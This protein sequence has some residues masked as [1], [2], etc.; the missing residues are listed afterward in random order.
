MKKFI[1]LIF[2]LFA[3]TLF[4]DVVSNRYDDSM[5]HFG[6]PGWVS[7]LPSDNNVLHREVVPFDNPEYGIDPRATIHFPEAFSFEYAGTKYSS[8]TVYRTGV[9]EFGPGSNTSIVQPGYTSLVPAIVMSVYFPG[10]HYSVGTTFEWGVYSQK[11]DDATDD[12]A[13]INFGPF[14]YE[15]NRY[16]AQIL[17]YRDGEVQVQFWK[18]DNPSS[19]YEDWM[20]PDFYDGITHRKQNYAYAEG[21]VYIYGSEGLRPGWIAKSLDVI[22]DVDITEPQ[23]GAGLLVQ[24]KSSDINLGGIIAYD[25][26]REHPVVGSIS[27]IDVVTSGYY[28]AENI[29][30]LY[31]WYFDEYYY[32]HTNQAGYPYFS[33]ETPS[34][35]LS[36]QNYNYTWNA[37]K[38]NPS[39]K[40]DFITRTDEEI[41]FIGAPAFKF[42]RTTVSH[43]GIHDFYINS[44]KYN[45]RQ[46]QSI[47][48]LPPRTKERIIIENAMGGLVELK[49]LQGERDIYNAYKKTYRLY[50]GQSVEGE[51]NATPS[52]FID[53]ITVT[54]A[55][56]RDGAKEIYKDGELRLNTAYGLSFSE[57]KNK[58]KIVISGHMTDNLVIVKITYK[59]CTDRKF[60]PIVPFMVKTESH[61]APESSPDDHAHL[62]A[63]I[64]DAFGGVAQKQKKIEDGK[65]SVSSVYTDEMNRVTRSPMAFVH[66]NPSDDF[67]YVDMACDNCIAEANNYYYM[68]SYG[69][70]A[71]GPDDD[72]DRPDARGNA[73]TE[74]RYYDSEKK[75]GALTASA[76]I[77]KRSFAL[78]NDDYA[79]SWEIPAESDHD[80]VPHRNLDEKNL[81]I[82]YSKR[83]DHPNGK[84]YILKIHRDAEGRFSQEIYDSKGQLVSSWRYDG[85]QESVVVYEYD[86]Y[87]LLLKSYDKGYAQI[88]YERTYDLQGRVK[89]TS[90]NDRGV[91]EY[92][93]DSFGR[94]RH[95]RTPRHAWRCFTANFYDDFGRLVAIGEVSKA[96]SGIFEDGDADILASSANVRY[97]SKIIYGK[98]E[99]SDLTSLGVDANLAQAILSNMQS[100]RENDV[101]AEISYD[102]N[103]N[104]LS[105]KLSDYD[106]LGRK[107]HQWVL[108]GISNA[109]ALQL[110]YTYNASNDLVSSSFDE[111]D[112]SQWVEK[113]SRTRYYN[114]E[115]RLISTFE[116]GK[117][118]ASYAYT[119]NGNL[120]NSVYYDAGDTVMVKTILRDVYGRPKGLRYE[121]GSGKELYSEKLSFDSEESGRVGR[122]SHGWDPLNRT[123]ITKTNEY[124]YDLPGRLVSV[125]GDQSASYEY[126]GLGRMKKK[127]EGDSLVDYIYFA[128]KF[129]PTGMNVNGRSPAG[130]EYLRYDAA[131]NVWL[132][133]YNKVAYKY[134]DLGLPTHVYSYKTTNLPQN[135]TLDDVNEG[136]SVMDGADM[137]IDYAYDGGQRVWT[138]MYGAGYDGEELTVPGVGT[139]STS[140]VFGNGEFDL[141]RMDLVAGGFRD[142]AGTARFPVTDAQGNI[143]GFATTQGLETAY[144]YYA[145]GT[146]IELV[147]TNGDDSRRWQGKEFDGQH[148]KY[149]FGARYFDPFFAL[150]M[151]PDPAGQ[152]LNPYTYGGD[153][154]N[155]VDPDGEWVHI[156][157]GAAIGAVIGASSALYQCTRKHGGSCATAVPIGYELGGAAGAA[158]AATGG[159][160]SGLTTAVV[161]EVGLAT[162]SGVLA[163]SAGAAVEGGLAGAAS[164]AVSYAGSAIL[165]QTDGWDWGDFAT[166][167]LVGLGTGVVMGGVTGA[168]SYGVSDTYK[169][170][171]YQ[172]V[173]DYGYEHGRHLDVLNF[174][175][176]VGQRQRAIDYYAHRVRGYTVDFKYD[177][178]AKGAIRGEYLDGK[179]AIY[180]EAFKAPDGGWNFDD[181]TSMMS[182][183]DH[184]HNHLVNNAKW[185]SEAIRNGYRDQFG[186]TIV[187]IKGETVKLEQP[188][189]SYVEARNYQLGLEQGRAYGYSPNTMR[190]LQSQIEGRPWVIQTEIGALY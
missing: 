102:E 48:F 20:I 167:T 115:G 44:I 100:V 190:Y 136:T 16:S 61:T 53:K 36:K 160:A 12:F 130:S 162:G 128:E 49:G 87:G 1:C 43:T 134:G 163:A 46:P 185:E 110:N 181:V 106:R 131:G 97:T 94:L 17:I 26:S 108:Y 31:C 85:T 54:Y 104:M 141:V 125:S 88:A 189:R 157:I 79:K 60:P 179:I 35:Q 77:A 8:L 74:I 30:R 133:A 13:V 159:A 18:H 111:W 161:G 103:E 4:A 143:R 124:A 39:E 118:L 188:G 38:T 170:N 169:Q 112:G 150:W 107:T 96:S 24:M 64:L 119:E 172:T 184:E 129:S 73:F 175:N 164:G 67:E 2:I 23:K 52:Y 42:Q 11:V 126:D 70:T 58:Q 173:E 78:R 91:T 55:T 95:V 10:K 176:A 105:V 93:Y 101:G 142:A 45:L 151:S 98:P 140:R 144:D 83:T 25:Y 156:V 120:K 33:N 113:S 122:A 166:S 174:D 5:G 84:N 158:A 47:Q 114:S 28:P 138:H 86:D 32:N 72:I 76:G 34:L 147:S 109:P 69:G 66:E 168:V 37:Y 139:Y 127:V 82:F 178:I 121:D 7:L 183:V 92:R 57:I 90:D 56:G 135:V 155:Y 19:E 40:K 132:D 75:N 148:G 137:Q 149:Y 81:E 14:T 3:K 51:I 123:S 182:T 62:T 6:M 153:P 22:Y 65:Y 186:T 41:D 154:V 187:K 180:D 50:V 145:Y 152:F 165:G 99:K 21:S 63:T 117:K 59:K 116:N 9:I 171:I 71:F 15:G 68:R 89:K 80:F 146:P 29:S 177:A 27:S